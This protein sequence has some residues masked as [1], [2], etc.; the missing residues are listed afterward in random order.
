M[1]L[2]LTW[3]IAT[4]KSTVAEFFRDK[5]IP[6]ICADTIAREIT[7]NQEI[8]DKIS[9]EFGKEM[10]VDGKL[11]RKKMR[12]YVF[13][14][15]NRVKKL[16]E[17]T[18]PPI[19]EKIKEEINKNKG[20]PILVVDIPLLF[21]GNYEFLVEK[22][23]LIT[24]RKEIQLLRVQNRDS[25]SLESAESII[26]KQMSME[27]K[28]KKSDFVIENNGTKEELNQKMEEFLIKISWVNIL[29]LFLYKYLSF[30][31]E[32]IWVKRYGTIIGSFSKLE[33]K[34]IWSLCHNV[35]GTV[36]IIAFFII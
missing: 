20:N 26:S 18:H 8:L 12:E 35:L 34:T 31:Q 28:E 4:G 7:K 33:A 30:F 29:N 23:L 32:F 2:G 21:E 27:E 9:V 10:I 22:I 13:V 5:K 25:V 24:C 19:I 3:G 17:I 6:V 14:D 15:I 36:Y 11:D 16:N 1:I